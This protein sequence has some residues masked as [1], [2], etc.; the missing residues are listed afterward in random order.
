MP[1]IQLNL[2]FIFW[3]YCFQDS[4]Y[5]IVGI[6]IGSVLYGNGVN[7]DTFNPS[8]ADSGYHYVYITDGWG[9]CQAWDSSLTFVYPPISSE[10]FAN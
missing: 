10:V 4:S 3:I 8:I 2:E 5:P 6:P 1:N 7:I 9:D